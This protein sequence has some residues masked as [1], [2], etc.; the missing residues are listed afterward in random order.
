LNRN[1]WPLSTGIYS[2][3]GELDW[4]MGE[5][6]D[7][8]LDHVSLHLSE[9]AWY[10]SFSGPLSERDQ[11]MVALMKRRYSPGLDPGDT[12][13]L[14]EAIQEKKL[15]NAVVGVEDKMSMKALDAIKKEFPKMHIR[16]ASSLLESTR[17]VK[18]RHELDSMIQATK[19]SARALDETHQAL[20]AGMSSE[21]I[22]DLLAKN[23]R[24]MGG[25]NPGVSADIGVYPNRQLGYKLKRGDLVVLDAVNS[26]NHRFG[27]LGM[28]RV[29]EGKASDK[30]SNS[31]KALSNGIQACREAARP[32]I[33]ITDLCNAILKGIQDYYPGYSRSRN[34]FGH[35]VGIECPEIP[36]L[37]LGN[38]TVLEP[39]MVLNPDILVYDYGSY[40]LL[41][42]NTILVTEKGCELVTD[43]ERTLSA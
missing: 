38:Q 11:R 31:H 6:L 40:M 3:V 5:L 18:N 43:I 22:R 39:G 14:I 28:S 26:V 16:N 23:L 19:I 29:F 15:E 36:I 37:T 9:G 17:S 21:E 8:D 27:D 42:E 34:V 30:L 32:G 25:S 4:C 41:V 2:F 33:T 13:A 12:G 35:S 1:H 24:K 20:T 10:N 7:C